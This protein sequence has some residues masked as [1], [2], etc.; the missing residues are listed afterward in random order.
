[1]HHP[2]ESLKDIVEQEVKEQS[3]LQKQPRERKYER[4]FGSLQ[5][6]FLEEKL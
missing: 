3:D 5:R 6:I 1:M 2:S 4:D